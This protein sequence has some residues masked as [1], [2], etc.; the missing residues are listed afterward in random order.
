M[1]RS[2]KNE[3]KIVFDQRETVRQL[4]KDNDN[5]IMLSVIMLCVIMLSVIVLNFIMLGV[6]WL[7]MFNPLSIINADRYC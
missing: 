4:G 2:H 1:V 3:I 6:S 5:G 7:G